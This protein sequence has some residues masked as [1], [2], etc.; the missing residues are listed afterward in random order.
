L[1]SIMA[2]GNGDDVVRLCGC[3]ASSTIAVGCLWQPRRNWRRTWP[4]GSPVRMQALST[5]ALCC[6]FV[7]ASASH[8]RHAHTM[9][10]LL[11]LDK[12]R[13]MQRGRTRWYA[14]APTCCMSLNLFVGYKDLINSVVLQLRAGIYKLA[15]GN[16]ATIYYRTL[17]SW[18]LLYVNMGWKNYWKIIRIYLVRLC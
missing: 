7:A 17:F 10:V 18:C 3:L 1:T 16:L 9:V 6:L 4:Q 2:T 15:I 13:D 5:I 8:R 11:Y 12:L 14:M